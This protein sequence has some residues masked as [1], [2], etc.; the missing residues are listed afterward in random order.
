MQPPQ[1]HEDKKWT[2]GEVLTW[3]I[4]RFKQADIETPLL[5]AQLLMCKV[6]N[7]T[8]IKLYTNYEQP[9]TLAE[10][11][12][13][14][15]FVKRRLSGEPVAYILK[16]KYWYN[17]KFF[18]D[19]RV[20]IPRPETECLLDFVLETHKFY[21]E[22]QN[23]VDKKLLIYDFC[24]GSG[25]LAIALA[26]SFPA[27]TI[28]AVDISQDALVVAQENASVN[29]VTNIEWLNLDLTKPQ[30][31]PFLKEKYG[32]AN[33]VVANPPYVSEEEWKNIDISVKNYEP[34]IALTADENG[35]FIGKTIV[36]N[37]NSLLNHERSIFAMEMAAQQPQKLIHEPLKNYLFNSS[38]QEKCVNKWF[39]LCDL[40]QKNRFLCAINFKQ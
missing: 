6:L 8:K 22:K 27:A 29:N 3:T 32:L 34:K 24:T 7:T 18:V 11:T 37:T 16:E 10:R 40:D 28:I 2:T 23:E 4:N 33:I 39:S 25:C 35:L 26:K 1:A 31:Y 36:Q 20:L 38:V 17:L 9:L 5:D 15:E 19:N 14:R 13:L 21:F 30:S 12:S